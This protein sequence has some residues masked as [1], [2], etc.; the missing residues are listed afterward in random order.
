MWN[1]QEYYD[2]WKNKDWIEISDEII[3]LSKVINIMGEKSIYKEKSKI[4]WEIYK[5]KG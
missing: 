2:K 3:K 5:N 4:L 1:S